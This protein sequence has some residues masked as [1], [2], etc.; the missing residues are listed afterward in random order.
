[1]SQF[2]LLVLREISTRGWR[3]RKVFSAVSKTKY[4]A[5]LNDFFYQA[6]S[7]TF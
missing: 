5:K 6:F 4:G 1:M 2:L 7:D 3:G